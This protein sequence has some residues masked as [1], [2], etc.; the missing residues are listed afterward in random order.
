MLR[1]RPATFTPPLGTLTVSAHLAPG[2]HLPESPA[3]TFRNGRPRIT[4]TPGRL[5]PESVAAIYRNGWPI[6]SGIRTH[7]GHHSAIGPLVTRRPGGCGS[8]KEPRSSW[9]RSVG[10][11]PKW[12]PP[13]PAPEAFPGIP[14]LGP[15][16]RMSGSQ[17]CEMRAAGWPGPKLTTPGAEL[18]RNLRGL[19]RRPVPGATARMSN[20]AC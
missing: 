10:S 5:P 19:R 17:L 4:G 6:C 7:S 14:V 11:H 13:N 20:P 9:S 12:R 1:R 15:V 2:R 3:R 8:R 16:F 18:A